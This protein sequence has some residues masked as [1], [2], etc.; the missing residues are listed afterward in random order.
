[1]SNVIDAIYVNGAFVPEVNCGLPSG[2][3]VRLRIEKIDSGVGDALAAIDEFDALCDEAP[4]DSGG[5]RLTRDELHDR[6]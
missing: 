6:I 2:S 4:I 3:K 5:T 1:M